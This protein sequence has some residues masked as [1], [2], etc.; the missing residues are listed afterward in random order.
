MLGLIVV[1]FAAVLVGL[2]TEMPP[3]PRVSVCVPVCVIEYAEP[4][5][6]IVMPP[7]V[8]AAAIF[9]STT[10]PALANTAVSPDPGTTPPTQSEPVFQSLPVLPHVIADMSNFGSNASITQ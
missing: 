5:L 10:V 6:S 3:L 9:G 1:V 4:L 8:V 2:L 7:T